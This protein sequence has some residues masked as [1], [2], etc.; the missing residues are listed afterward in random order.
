MTQDLATVEKPKAGEIDYAEQRRKEASGQGVLDFLDNYVASWAKAANIAEELARTDYAGQ[1]KGK[2]ADLAAAIL[3]AATLGIP[4]Q[5]V[6]KSIYV[7]H[8]VPALYGETALSLA[9]QAGYTHE[10]LQYTDKVVE[11]RF[12]R[13]DGTP[14]DVK[15][16]FSRAEREGLVAGNKQQYTRRPEKML[17]WK[18]VGE[19]A[20][21]LFP[22]VTKGLKVKEDI[23]QSSPGD[24]RN[25]LQATA[26][27]Q[28][29]ASQAEKASAPKSLEQGSV[30]RDWIGELKAAPDTGALS[31]LMQEAQ[32][33]DMPQ[34]QYQ[35]LADA[36]N[37]RWE[38]LNEAEGE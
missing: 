21:Q 10:K 24:F 19:A 29:V 2:P 18:C 38:E 27:R 30:P 35:E 25:R 3:E 31:A 1:F 14:Y 12:Y 7:V 17:F 37:D 11:L 15:Y 28:D 6:G 8:G 22:H 20:D 5:Q 4:P 16:T 13:P 9:L 26:T 23:E 34:E 33:A 36:A 32:E